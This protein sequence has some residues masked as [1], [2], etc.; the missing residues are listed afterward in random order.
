MTYPRQDL[1]T[2]AIANGLTVRRCYNELLFFSEHGHALFMVHADAIFDP[3]GMLFSL[4][5]VRDATEA[6][7]DLFPT[8]GQEAPPIL[9]SSPGA[10]VR[11]EDASLSFEREG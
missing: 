9:A 5:T 8:D 2:A 6:E 10:A 7:K 3:A 4:S 11:S 1:D